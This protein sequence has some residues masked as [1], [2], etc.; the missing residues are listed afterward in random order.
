MKFFFLQAFPHYDILEEKIEHI[1]NHLD[2]SKVLPELEKKHLLKPVDHKLINDKP[3]RRE[4]ITSLVE[5][6]KW[7]TDRDYN[8]FLTVL[9]AQNQHHIIQVLGMDKEQI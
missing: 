8:A 6:M 9:H 2:L 1:Q 7:S 3:T 4:M 5:A